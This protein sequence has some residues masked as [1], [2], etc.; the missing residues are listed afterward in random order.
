MFIKKMLLALLEYFIFFPI[1][2]FLGKMAI[3]ESLFVIWLVFVYLM[4]VFCIWLGDI[5]SHRSRMIAVI[6][7]IILSLGPVYLVNTHIIWAIVLFLFLMSLCLR[8]F[9]YSREILAKIIPVKLLWY[10]MVGY[11]L[12]YFVFRFH[13]SLVNDLLTLN[14]VG[15]FYVCLTLFYSNH[16]HIKLATLSDREKPMIGMATKRQNR[17]L[18]F[19]TIL[20]AALLA[21]ASYLSELLNMLRNAIGFILESIGSNDGEYI[22]LE[23]EM[24]ANQLEEMLGESEQNQSS[25]WVTILNYFGMILLVG[26]LV[27]ILIFVLKGLRKKLAKL[28]NWLKKS[29]KKWS[30]RNKEEEEADYIDEKE[31]LINFKKFTD[32]LQKR[33]K[34]WLASKFKKQ[35]SLED[36][37]TNQEKIRHLFRL[38]IRQEVKNGF[39]RKNSYTANEMLQILLSHYEEDK[40]VAILQ[41]NYSRARYSLATIKDS[42]VEK[43]RVWVMERIQN[44]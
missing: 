10:G 15:F 7:A 8:G 13:S 26:G 33:S 29:L 2:L 25:F 11:V 38:F 37:S 28:F 6:S 1:I 23:P 31:K 9:Y 5:F 18:I 19:L 43:L 20:F 12:F 14:I 42:D 24:P 16:V 22:P 44:N 32:E 39:V 30:I 35:A 36:Y 17:F 41:E 3:G 27:F 34:D 4:F 40:E 21:N